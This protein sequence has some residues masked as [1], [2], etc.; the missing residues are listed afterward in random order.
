MNSS[1]KFWCFLVLLPFFMAVGHDIYANYLS[2]PEKQ[3]RLESFQIDPKSY[4]GSDLGYIFVKYVPNEYRAV[5]DLIGEDT[6]GKYFEPVLRQYTFVVCLVPAMLFFTWLLF[7][8][9]FDIWPFTPSAPV[10]RRMPGSSL[11]QEDKMEFKY[12][13]R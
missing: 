7:A 5:R 8:R 12:K 9:I 10:A 2:S 13:R 3:M 4:Q 11:K 1:I 6:W